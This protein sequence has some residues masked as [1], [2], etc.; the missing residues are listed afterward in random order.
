[1]ES[2]RPAG[3]T[4]VHIHIQP[5]EHLRPGVDRMLR[6]SRA[7]D[8]LHLIERCQADP[9]AL[10]AEMDRC[11]VA[12]AGLINYTSRLMGFGEDVNDWVVA[13]VRGRT[14]R[15]IAFG[16]PDPAR[17]GDVSGRIEALAGAG[18]RGI[19]IHPP[20]MEFSPNAYTAEPEHPLAKIYETAQRLGLPV[21]FHTGT[22]AFPGARSRLGDPMLVDDVAVDFP[23]MKIILAHAGRPLWPEAS[24]FLA[25]RHPNVWLDLSGIPARRIPQLLPRLDVIGTK[26]LYGSDW[27]GPGV[28]SMEACLEGFWSLALPEKL[29]TA[30][31]V[32]NSRAVFR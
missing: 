7:G 22:S 3:V 27:P 5:W 20:H 14:D 11:G 8:D 30:L 28:P 6:E 2:P 31:F 19:K 13:Y 9:G 4:D 25:R 23:E 24:F 15:L 26:V 18:L 1:M 10:L 32:E 12:R 29:K 21:M 17:T 16:C